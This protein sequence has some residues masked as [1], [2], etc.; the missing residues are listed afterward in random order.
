MK[1]VQESMASTDVRKPVW[2][3]PRLQ[4]IGNLRDF[5]REGNA[6]GKSGPCADGSTSGN[7]E[8]MC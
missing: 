3:S 8:A 4:R 7:N 6:Y 2:Q 1:A 5:V